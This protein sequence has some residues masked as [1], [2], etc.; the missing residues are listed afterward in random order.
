MTNIAPIRT[1]KPATII[2]TT[3]PVDTDAEEEWFEDDEEG[4]VSDVGVDV[5]VIPGSVMSRLEVVGVD[6]PSNKLDT[7]EAAE[8]AVS[9]PE[10]PAAFGTVVSVTS[11]WRLTSS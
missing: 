2:A 6:D 1:R 5:E 9:P 7:T 3:D 8:V 4:V 10:T 11:P